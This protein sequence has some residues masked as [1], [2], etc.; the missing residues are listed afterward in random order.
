MRY[1]LMHKN[2]PVMDLLI[3][4]VGQIT[5]ITKIHDERHVPIGVNFDKTKVN[6]LDMVNWWKSRGIPANR[7][8]LIYFFENHLSIS[9]EILQKISYGLSL[10]DQYWIN[11]EL[12][13]F[14]W[15]KINFFENPFS[16][17]VGDILFE[18]KEISMNDADFK[19]PDT[20]L[21]GY[22]QKRWFIKN[23]KRVLIKAGSK[24]YLQEPFNEVIC[25]TILKN[26]NINHVSYSLNII[27]D[28]PY[29][30][31]ETFITTETE[32]IPAAHILNCL[33][34]NEK[35][36]RYEHFIK[37]CE[38]LGI[39][40]FVTDL[41]K[42]ITFDFIVVN[43]DRHFG[44]FGFVR[45]ANS[46]EWISFCPI[47]DNGCSFWYNTP[48]N[49]IGI[50]AESKGFEFNHSK[51]IQLVNSFDW[52]DLDSIKDMEDIILDVL[53]VSDIIAEKRSMRIAEKIKARHF[54]LQ[55]LIEK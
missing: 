22:L 8:E 30:S 21:N 52:F 39:S 42:M 53:S 13:N 2:I 10:T 50:Y 49:K 16:A 46:L 14:K 1:T 32:F 51:K 38:H 44:N 29:C 35:H 48:S 19:S 3:D 54:I 34:K 33:K 25:S 18:K 15:E 17:D 31:C 36:S 40:G 43:E 23:D 11:P 37:C 26:M 4:D 7:D 9:P 12:F 24:P 6:H 55:H 41:D 5:E 20:S 28:N 47:F 45:D 27:N